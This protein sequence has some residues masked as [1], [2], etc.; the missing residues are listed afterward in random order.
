MVML[1]NSLAS[2]PDDV[3]VGTTKMFKED[4]NVYSPPR[5]LAS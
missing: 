3:Y 1:R 4:V 5:G 2:F